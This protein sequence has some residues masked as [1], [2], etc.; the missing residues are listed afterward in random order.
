L[1]EADVL[2]KEDAGDCPNLGELVEAEC[3][4]FE[5]EV[6]QDD[7]HGAE[8]GHFP[9]VNRWNRDSRF[10]KAK[11]A[12][13]FENEIGEDQMAGGQED[14]ALEILDA[15]DLLVDDDEAGRA[16]DAAGD[17]EDGDIHLEN[18]DNL[19]TGSVCWRAP[20]NTHIH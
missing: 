13:D 16:Y 10:E 7:G 11:A 8:E 12:D 20:T 2:V 5:V 1:L 3:I 9:D 17:E 6:H 4:D 18:L 19:A 15:Q 14:G